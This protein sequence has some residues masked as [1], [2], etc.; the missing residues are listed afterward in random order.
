MG[1]NRQQIAPLIVKYLRHTISEEEMSELEAWLKANEQNKRLLASFE[2][3]GYSDKEIAFVEHLNVDAAWKRVS[4]RKGRKERRISLIKWTT[5]FAALIALIFGL[6]LWF[7]LP[8][9]PPSS[10]SIVFHGE[11]ILPGSKKAELILSD[12]TKLDLTKP[13]HTKER[14]GTRIHDEGGNLNYLNSPAAGTELIF[15]TLNVPKTGTYQLTLPDGTKVWLNAMSTLKFP[16]QFLS[17]ER[18]VY[19]EGEAYFE[20]AE[21]PSKPFVVDVRN[22]K[23]SVLGTTFNINAYTANTAA[24]LI[25][26]AV[27]VSHKDVEELLRP[28][29]EAKV[30]AD[31]ISVRTADLNKVVAWK[32]GDFYFDKDNIVEIMQELQRWYDFD[33]TY[34]GEI[35]KKLI[36]GN[37][38]RGSKLSEVLEMLNFVSN[39]STR[40]E[41]NDRTVSVLFPEK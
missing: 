2:Q 38:S 3:D 5:S 21:D 24:T 4:A 20:V 27:K 32:Q 9:S 6:K 26:G 34:S 12:G 29:Q 1:L 22:T 15:N 18:L 40:F 13:V 23:V 7:V 19:L 37:I 35:P 16:V 8:K 17:T 36:S 11:D 10:P 30:E 39:D 25:S 33:V 14:N 31:K 28:G 41:V